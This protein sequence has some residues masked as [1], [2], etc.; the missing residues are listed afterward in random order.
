MGILMYLIMV[1]GIRASDPYGLNKGSQVQQETPEEG[2]RIYQLKHC[3]Y[4]SKDE[5]NSQK[6]LN[7]KNSHLL[8][9]YKIWYIYILD[10]VV[11]IIITV[12]KNRTYM[13]L[14]LKV[15]KVI[16]PCFC[17]YLFL[18]GMFTNQKII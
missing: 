14:V 17:T 9:I 11:G 18:F 6:T 16:C 2:Q 4:N 3:E 1:N 12:S 8:D 15:V 5:D 13:L 7:D 10:P